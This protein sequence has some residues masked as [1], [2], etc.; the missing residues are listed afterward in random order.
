MFRLPHCA[1][2]GTPVVAHAERLCYD[3]HR[4]LRWRDSIM[5]AALVVVA[6]AGLTGLLGC[7][8]WQRTSLASIRV[9]H[10][11]GV[12]ARKAASADVCAAAK[13]KCAAA[14]VYRNCPGLETCIKARG[15]VLDGLT[16]LQLALSAGLDALVAGDEKSASGAI[17]AAF[18][19]GG[20]ICRAIKVWTAPPSACSYLGVR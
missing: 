2:C 7:G 17:E 3:C 18:K 4:R 1:R 13:D 16:T 10:Q 6:L 8:S 11:I 20:I 5:G 12:T 19:V 14:K 9:A 15:A